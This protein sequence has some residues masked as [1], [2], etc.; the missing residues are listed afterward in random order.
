MQQSTSTFIIWLSLFFLY[1]FDTHTA[2]NN[3][4][5]ISFPYGNPKAK[6]CTRL[7]LSSSLQRDR[8][9]FTVEQPSTQPP[10]ILDAEVICPCPQQNAESPR[11]VSRTR[12]RMRKVFSKARS[13]MLAAML[14]LRMGAGGTGSLSAQG[15]SVALAREAP[16]TSSIQRSGLSTAT[17]SKVGV[18][19]R[20]SSHQ[21]NLPGGRGRR[22]AAVPNAGSRKIKGS[23][24][25]RVN[26]GESG[27]VD[28]LDPSGKRGTRVRMKFV[29][30]FNKFLDDLHFPTEKRDTLL[31]LFAMAMVSPICAKFGVSPILGFL[32]LGTAMGPSG[33]KLISNVKTT[34]KLAEL[35]IVFFLFEMGLELSVERL[36]SMKKDVFGLGFSQFFLSA[37]VIAGLGKLFTDLPGAALVTI[38]GGLALSSSAF[39]LQLLKDKEDMGTRYGKAS[40]GILLFQDLAVVPLLVA[41]PLFAGGGGSIYQAIGSA[42]A[43]AGL[44]LGTIALLGRYA[45]SPLFFTVAKS[46]SQEAFLSIILATVLGMSALSEG[47]GLSDT[48]GAFLAGVLLSETKYRY[49]VE[50]DVAPFRG[51]LLGLF[52]MSVGFE[53]DLHLITTQFGAVAATVLSIL[54]VKS[55]LISSLCIG[56]G[57]SPSSAQQTGLL[58]S[59]GGEFAF[60]AFG[61]ASRLGILNEYYTKL[62]MTSVALTMAT[63]PYLAAFSSKIADRIANKQGFT[64]YLGR[65]KQAEQIK[66][67]SDGFVVVCGYGRIGKMVCDLLD[68]K[69]IKYVCFE[70]NPDKVIQARNKGLNVFFGDVSRPDVLES[71]NIQKATSVVITLSDIKGTNKVTYNLR[72]EFPDMPIFVRAKNQVHRE[73]LQSTLNVNAMVPVLPED[74]MLVSL[75]FGGAVLRSLGVS[76]E[77]VTAILEKTRDEIIEEKGIDGLDD[78]TLLEAL[79]LEKGGEVSIG[80]KGANKDKG[81]SDEKS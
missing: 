47:L 22:L 67:D 13:L 70:L 17:V 44:C 76:A 23:I 2:F 55:A 74:S 8:A 63:T 57:L 38:G 68:Q 52:F 35:G 40:F 7:S 19:R 58:L 34:A 10:E 61:L 43:K 75:P 27:E 56:F 12:A 5:F 81:S 1:L 28:L 69:F 32:A 53:I 26:L 21:W 42:G 62:L 64:F 41:I 24:A 54:A 33:F 20:G 6:A 4:Q 18:R 15:D 51:I 16:S 36:M 66:T 46:K 3:D 11:P 39:V 25:P 77:E 30:S 50:A 79:G 60:V 48:L 9:I 80:T 78:E 65:D 14:L 49:Q 45:V 37:A 29:R 59:Q 71:F 72:K 31:L 73:R